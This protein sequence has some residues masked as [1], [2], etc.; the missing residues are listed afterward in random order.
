M[1]TDN[2]TTRRL[3]L[4][5]AAA[6][7]LR[8][9]MIVTFKTYA[10]PFVWEY[11]TIANNLLSGEGYSFR[12][13]NTTYWSSGTPLFAVLCAGIYAVTNHSYLAVLV[14]QSLFSIALALTIFSIGKMVFSE[15][16]GL[17]A[18]A[19]VAFHPGFV[20]YDVF[21][22]LPLSIDSFL[23]AVIALLLLKY[24]ERQHVKT[25][26]L[27][28]AVIGIAVLSR[29][30]SGVLL[31]L[32]LTYLFSFARRL[33]LKQRLKFAG[34]VVA[35]AFLVLSP[36]LIRNYVVHK[37]FVFIST[38][39]GE[40][41]WRG[42][43]KHATGTLSDKDKTKILNLWPTDFKD[44][45]SSMSELEQKKFFETEAWR[46]IRENPAEATRLYLKK[47]YYFWWFSPQSGIKYPKSYLTAYR[48]FYL[49]LIIFSI[50]GAGFALRSSKREVREASLILI[51]IPVTISLAQSLFYVE[52]RHRWLV[53]PLI[54]IFFA[55]GVMKVL[56]WLLGNRVVQNR[57]R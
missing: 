33:S 48:F 51:A 29:G 16:V 42:N 1:I 7:I 54:I 25:M 5:L 4:L 9:A 20:Y 32:V 28:G 50:V 11:E 43:N 40:L 23:I 38:S 13:L 6:F 52:G 17:L 3:V 35:A 56:R 12:Y 30:I 49:V 19:L 26:L 37:Q 46:F 47:I 31:L 45:V 2:K 21:N 15:S 39:T 55:Y 8:I 24:R 10:H 57:E 44:R 34:C 18:A 41:F 53:E 22:L 27:L 36:W 14:V